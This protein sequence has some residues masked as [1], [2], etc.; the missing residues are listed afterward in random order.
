MHYFWNSVIFPLLKTIRASTIVE[1]GAADGK[2]TTHIAKYLEQV[3]GIVHSIDTKRSASIDALL[4][5]YPNTI[6]FYEE[7]SLTALPKIRGYDAVLIDG[8]HNWYTVFHELQLIHE[9]SRTIGRLPLILLHDTAWPYARRDLY[10]DPTTIPPAYRHP[11]ATGGMLPAEHH[12]L[13]E[14]GLNSTLHHSVDE[15]VPRCG[16]LSAVEDF[17]AEHSTDYL[18]Q[19]IPGLYGIGILAPH[20]LLA[21]CPELRSTLQAWEL[22][23]PIAEHIRT[24]EDRRLTLITQ[25][26]TYQRGNACLMQEKEILSSTNESL[27]KANTELLQ[28]RQEAREKEQEFLNALR[29]MEDQMQ[30]QFHAK[31]LTIAKERRRSEE[32]Q[33]ASKQLQSTLDHILQTRSWRWMHGLRIAGDFVSRLRKKH[34]PPAVLRNIPST[35]RPQPV[36]A[37][38]SLPPVSAQALEEMPKQSEVQ[39]STMRIKRM[40]KTPLVSAVLCSNSHD[41]QALRRMLNSTVQQTY[42]HWELHIWHRKTDTMTLRIVKDYMA[43]YGDKI[44]CHGEGTASLRDVFTQTQGE[45]LF[46][47][48]ERWL[49]KPTALETLVRMHIADKAQRYDACMSPYTTADLAGIPLKL[50]RID[51]KKRR[52][53]NDVHVCMFRRSALKELADSNPKLQFTRIPELLRAISSTR[54][55]ISIHE[56]PLCTEFA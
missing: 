7:P 12:S 43:R 33:A 15:N 46:P 9:Q 51:T 48:F 41:E 37:V 1:I 24:L 38:A 27:K 6:R 42:P 14:T 50:Q 29:T 22:Q 3:R 31:D 52:W 5:T 19:T 25:L 2:S 30:R 28:M 40:T 45:L 32:L 54:D 21:Q 26:Q 20:Q 13:S 36:D 11:Y 44:H 8:D 18:L 53:Y 16:V 49:L 47:L 55:T 10:Y 35:E 39:L 4:Q 23:P 56:T 34:V 17:L